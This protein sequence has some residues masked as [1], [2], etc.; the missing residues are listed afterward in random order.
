M[1]LKFS[2]LTD[3]LLTFNTEE[4]CKSHFEQVRWNGKIVCPHCKSTEHTV[5][6]TIR[7]FRCLNKPC[8]KKFTVTV[9]TVLE[10]TNVPLQ[11]WFAAIYLFT[12]HKKGISSLQLGRDIGVCQ[13]TAWFMLH[14][15]REAFTLKEDLPKLSGNIQADETYIGGKTKNMHKDKRM[16]VHAAGSS[17]VHANPVFGVM[18]NGIVRAIP[19]PSPD[20]E[21]IMPIIEAWVNKNA[22]LVTDGH[23][24]YADAKKTF[25]H[26]IINHSQDEFVR[27][28]FHT[29]SIEGFW[30]LLK[31]GIYGIYHQ[32]SGKHLARYCNE[33]AYRYNLRN[34]TDAQRFNLTLGNIE[35]RIT[36]KQLTA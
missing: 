8:Y 15:I 35:G 2:N 4:K 12:A 11:K 10:N 7:G 1:E 31:R 34:I 14:R 5:S 32:T 20:S 9:G 17:A 30:S 36:Y 26:E 18:N 29:N 13:K 3:L 27:N 25:T 22:T 28:G 19:V 23:G 21:T 33:F 6:R 24:A 16:V